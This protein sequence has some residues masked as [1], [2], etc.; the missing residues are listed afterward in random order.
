MGSGMATRWEQESVQGQ[1]SQQALAVAWATLASL[2]VAQC[3]HTG[4]SQGLLIPQT[5]QHPKSPST[6][7]CRSF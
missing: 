5:A 6:E 2:H 7:P 4:H 1:V 3:D